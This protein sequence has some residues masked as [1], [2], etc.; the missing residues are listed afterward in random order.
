MIR[1]VNHIDCCGCGACSLSCPVGCISMEQGPG[2]FLYPKVDEAACIGC[3]ACESACP[4]LSR[5]P[6]AEPVSVFAAASGEKPVRQSSS[7]GGMF[8]ELASRV[9]EAGGVVFGAAFGRDWTVVGS[10]AESLSE[11]AALRGSKY[12]QADMRASFVECRRFLEEGRKVLF[13]GTP[14]QIAGLKGF[15]GGEREGLLTVDIVCHSVP[16]PD[17]WKLYLEG[18]PH[19]HG[20]FRQLRGKTAGEYVLTQVYHENPFMKAFLQDVI[21][22]PSCSGCPSRGKRSSADITLGDFWGIEAL[23]PGRFADEGCS[24]AIAHTEKG[25]EALEYSGAELCPVSFGQAAASN[26]GLVSS[27]EMDGRSERFFAGMA[28]CDAVSLMESLVCQPSLIQRLRRMKTRARAGI[29][30]L[31]KGGKVD[32]QPL[33]VREKTLLEAALSEGRYTLTDISFRDKRTG[34]KNYSLSITVRINDR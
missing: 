5:R 30:R 10:K 9:L 28:S 33:D 7:S 31:L 6:E 16:S 19:H 15:L 18:L 20:G 1:I 4:M 13:A 24:L 2:G 29:V 3:G 23:M 22:R 21:T 12:S 34:W 17:A 11:L 8:T 26:R 25:R 32:A 14:C 27:P